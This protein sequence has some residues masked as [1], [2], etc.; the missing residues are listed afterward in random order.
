M[1]NTLLVDTVSTLPTLTQY[2][3]HLLAELEHMGHQAKR[4][5]EA[6][7]VEPKIRKAEE[8]IKS[9]D[10]PRGKGKPV[11]EVDKKKHPRK[12]IHAAFLDRCRLQKGKELPIRACHGQSEALLVLWIKGIALLRPAHEWKSG[13]QEQQG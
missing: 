1:R 7:E 9:E 12:S 8:T 4:K 11:E 3:E 10:T 6:M 2:S 5:E 13:N